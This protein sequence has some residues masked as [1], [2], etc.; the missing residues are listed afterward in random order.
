MKPLAFESLVQAVNNYSMPSNAKRL[1]LDSQ[2]MIL[3]GVTAAGKNTI[4]SYLI[5][6]QQFAYVVSHSTRLPRINHGELEKNGVDY[7]FVSQAEMYDLVRSHAF[8]EV[9]VI[10]QD[11][12]SGTSLQSIQTAIDTHKRPITE[13]DVQGAAELMR[14]IPDFRPFFVLPP[15]FEIWMKRLHNRG[16]ISSEDRLKRM[17]SAQSELATAIDDPQFIL[18]VNHEVHETAAEI[19]QGVDVREETQAE[20]R[21]LAVQLSKELE[22]QLSTLDY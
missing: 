11:T 13:I 1:V 5:E 21:T 22:V 14:E 12:V 16:V 4:I 7:W 20:R 6:H 17:R 18:L 19:V 15:N 2:L 3:C 9:K 10:H 8:L